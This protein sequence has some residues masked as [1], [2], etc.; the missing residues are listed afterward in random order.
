MENSS[1]L[2]HFEM[3]IPIFLNKKKSFKIKRIYGPYPLI[4]SKTH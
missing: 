4:E 2:A 1:D 3:K